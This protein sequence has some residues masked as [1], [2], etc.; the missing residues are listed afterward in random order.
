MAAKIFNIYP[1]KGRIAVGSDAD[2]VI[3]DPKATRTI[4]KNTHHQAVDFNIFEGMVVHGVPE[5]TISRGKVVW[6]NST[7]T[8]EAGAGRFIP[9]PPFAPIAFATIPQRAKAMAPRAVCRDQPTEKKPEQMTPA[10][11]V[12]NGHTNERS[13]N[14]TRR[15]PPG[16][17]SSIQFF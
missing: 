15:P 5:T 13:M 12:Q 4:S 7:L 16:G 9:L 3:W 6:S 8:V 17:A 1:K 14:T 11:M 10:T 2:L